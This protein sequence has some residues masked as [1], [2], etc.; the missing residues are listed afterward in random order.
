[1]SDI[2]EFI[3]AGRAEY[4]ATLI[5]SGGTLVNVA[6]GEIYPTDVAVYKDRI[7]AVG[8]VSEYRG[9]ETEM[10]DATGHFLC[11]GLIDGHLHVECSKM[12]VTSFAKAVVPLGT[13]S[14]VSGLDQILVVSGLEGAREFL[15]EAKGTP[16]KIFWGAPCKTPYTLPRS[17]VGYYF[18]PDDHR[19]T[20]SWPECVGI[21]ETVREFVDTM[22]EHVLQA[23]E[24]AEKSRLPILGCSPMCRGNRLNSYL[25]AGVRSDHESYTADEMLEKLRKGMHVVIRESSISHFLEE[26]L[27]IVTEM[28]IGATNRISFCTDDVVA[29]DIL[30]RG[31]L[32]N[33]IRMAVAMGVPPLTAIQMA[34]INGAEALR[35]GQKVG[36]ISPGLAADI[37]LV[38]DIGDFRV[39]AVIAKGRLAARD[40]RL[41]DDLAP[42]A[43]SVL[44]TDTFKLAPVSRE[45]LLV[46]AP[47]AGDKASVLTIAVTPEQIFVRTQRDVMLPV[48]DGYVEADPSQDVQYL[49]VVERY[50]RTSNRPVA[51]A[52]GF[53]LRS[54][55]LATSTAP[56]DNNIVCLGTNPDDMALAINHIIE[57]NGG[58]VVTD[59]GRIVSFLPLPIGGI[60]SDLDPPEMAKKELELDDAARALGC[61]LPWPFMYMFVLQI[62]AIPDFAITDLGL[63]DCVNLKVVNPLK[64]AL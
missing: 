5:V 7:V 12:S 40:G 39:S 2:R 60:V 3:R 36:S 64:Q 33:M 6:S 4:K 47:A 52:S 54:G 45:D 37:L 62:T 31:H 11:P 29:S 34:T 1:M 28:G 16:L 30:G 38:K 22:D 10:I 59:G 42:P 17:N 21:W 63:I 35:I 57:N 24:I 44:V 61:T 32:D 15:D 50:G 26:N 55:A 9:P 20:H 14:I 46:R 41:V 13:T 27:R 25:Q 56:D 23:V 48:R 58:Q 49:T 18:G 8:D 53:G 19:A 51:F 43:R